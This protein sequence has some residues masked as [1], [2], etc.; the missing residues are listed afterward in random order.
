MSPLVMFNHLL[1]VNTFPA[2]SLPQSAPGPPRDPETE[3]IP[4][5]FLALPPGPRGGSSISYPAEGLPRS[6]KVTLPNRRAR[7]RDPRGLSKG[8]GP[9]AMD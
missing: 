1:F 6:P 7:E 8:P 4:I 9:L 2:R 3:N 5:S